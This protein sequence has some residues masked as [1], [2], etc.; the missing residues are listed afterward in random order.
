MLFVR[1]LCVVC[2]GIL[3]D[4]VLYIDLGPSGDET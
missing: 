4:Q 2:T 3:Y 1:I